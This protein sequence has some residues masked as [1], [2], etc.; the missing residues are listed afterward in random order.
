LPKILNASV[1]YPALP[2]TILQYNC[3]IVPCRLIYGTKEQKWVGPWAGPGAGRGSPPGLV[4]SPGEMRSPRQISGV[5][6]CAGPVAGRRTHTHTHFH[7]YIVDENKL[8]LVKRCC[9]MF[10]ITELPG[11]KVAYYQAIQLIFQT[12]TLY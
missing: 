5:I 6:A 12:I 3:E 11:G 2:G 8:N 9:T 7:L 10:C 4:Q 1:G